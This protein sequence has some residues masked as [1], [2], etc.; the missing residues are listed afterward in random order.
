MFSRA[1]DYHVERQFRKDPS[2]RLVFLPF[3]PKGKAY[4]VD[5]KADEEKI[6]ASVKKYRSTSALLSLLVY[7]G[8]YIPSLVLNVYGGGTSLRHK[9][10]TSIGISSLVLLVF[11]ALL[12]MVWGI[13][14]DTVASLTVP[15]S[16]VGPD[17][18]DQ[19]SEISPSASGRVRR[20]ALV[21]AF[22]AII[23][24]GLAILA[25]TR[26]ARPK[27]PCPPTITSSNW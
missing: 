20:I 4:F 18:K 13:Y 25:A 5:S 23:L 24:M 8:I 17:L 3:G 15:L 16:E 11:L 2:G 7:P 9:L 10:T 22:G 27:S 21:C 26:Y 6:K 1:M 12:W 14:K 19:L